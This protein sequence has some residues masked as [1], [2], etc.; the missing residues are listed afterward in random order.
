MKV[1]LSLAISSYSTK[2]ELIIVVATTNPLQFLVQLPEVFLSWS[3]VLE[4]DENRFFKHLND[5]G[6]EFWAGLADGPIRDDALLSWAG[7]K[8]A[9]A[10]TRYIGVRRCD[11]ELAVMV[12]LDCLVE[13]NVLG[14]LNHK[15]DKAVI[16]ALAEHS[17]QK[18]WPTAER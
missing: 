13:V 10:M 15:V 7:I 11:D 12:D 2:Q 3:T 16:K 1:S 4:I 9:C 18:L 6:V 5:V 14:N 17:M 8:T